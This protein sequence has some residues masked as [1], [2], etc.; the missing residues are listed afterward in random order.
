MADFEQAM[1]ALDRAEGVLSDHPD[2]AGGMTYR[3]IARNF[4]PKW[5]GWAYVDR[6]E[7]VPNNLVVLFYKS[8]F[9]TPIR[10][11][12]IINQRVAYS[13]FSYSVNAGVEPAVTMA[14]KVLYVGIDGKVGPVTTFALNSVDPDLF[15][16]RFALARIAHRVEVCK[17]R[18][19]QK[20]FLI[21]WLDR[22]LREAK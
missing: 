20:E 2:D 14:Q 16:A 9:W 4:H 12:K 19:S 1:A 8:V 7:P 21:G 6:G 15:L 22:D 5:A 3:G 18:P 13:L 17:K 11:D 10:G